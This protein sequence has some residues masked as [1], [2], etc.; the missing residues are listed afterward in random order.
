[1]DRR[2]LFDERFESLAW[3]A[4]KTL[5]LQL[6]LVAVFAVILGLNVGWG[7]TAGWLAA[8]VVP[9]AWMRIAMRPPKVSPRGFWSGVNC[10]AA[11]VAGSALWTSASIIFWLSGNP[12]LRTI[13]LVLL[14]S[15]L[16]SAHSLSFKSRLGVAAFGAA[17]ALAIIALPVFFGGFGPMVTVSVALSLAIMLGYLARDV[18]QISAH[19]SA[20]VKAQEAAIAANRA[21]SSFLAMMSHELRTPMNGVLGMAHALSLTKLNL[22][23]AS[24]VD[25]IVRSGGGLMTILNDILDISKIEAGKME[26]E[27]IDFDLHELGQRVHHLWTETASAKG[28]GLVL[29]LD[30]ATPRWVSGDPTRLR[31]VLTNLVSNALKFTREGEVRISIRPNPAVRD[32]VLQIAVSDTGAGMTEAQ[33]GKLFQSFT[34]AA[35]STTREYGGTGLGLAICKQLIDLMGGH[36]GVTSAPGAGST[37]T[38]LV[39]LPPA[40]PVAEHTEE[41]SSFEGLEGFRVLVA[42][43]NAINQAVAGAILEAV[44]AEVVMADDGL[45]ALERL[46]GQAFDVVLMDV[47]MPRMGG[48]EALGAIRQGLAGHPDTPVI[49]LTADAMAGV[50]VGLLARG[51]DA[52]APKP[53]NPTDLVL[54]IS[55]LVRPRQPAAEAMIG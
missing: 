31:Q 13:S 37:F 21:K 55:G 40:D 52:V 26:L 8:G 51:F 29:D 46:R 53:I 42:D 12:G 17:P 6:C 1:M 28:V 11:M 45:D 15:Q 39:R 41:A 4:R 38:V 9:F 36:I 34:Q 30:A 32:D 47:H 50:D 14:A 27:I 44:G 33:Q 22:R 19:A 25:M 5:G 49:A 23:Q 16:I 24:H 10:L 20:L 48:V 2:T 7:L 54:A 3:S 35:A 18:E 43:D